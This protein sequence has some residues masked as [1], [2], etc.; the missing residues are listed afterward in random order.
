[1]ASCLI[2][3][4]AQQSL[5]Q[6]TAQRATLQPTSYR[7]SSRKNQRWNCGEPLPAP[8][9]QLPIP[10][11]VPTFVRAGAR[12]SD[13][14]QCPIR[15][16]FPALIASMNS[17]ANPGGMP[18]GAPR[19]LNSLAPLGAMPSDRRLLKRTKVSQFD[20]APP[21]RCSVLATGPRWGQ[22][23]DRQPSGS[24]ARLP[25]VTPGAGTSDLCSRLDSELSERPAGQNCCKDRGR[26]LKSRSIPI[27]AWF[28]SAV[29]ALE[30][31]GNLPV[32]RPL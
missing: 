20:S 21:G 7:Q 32:L 9:S 18:G 4:L 30:P 13:Y 6:P 10:E 8:A 22:S 3:L 14:R 5:R 26:P 25:S 31:S 11:A 2:A 27:A 1:M 15:I 29:G 28:A 17:S 16:V 23:H 12:K 24:S 19:Y